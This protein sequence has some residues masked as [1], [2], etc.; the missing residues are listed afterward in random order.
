MLSEQDSSFVNLRKLS[1][2]YH[3]TDNSIM[4]LIAQWKDFNNSRV[5]G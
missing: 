5:D 4:V 2:W 1:Y 3:I